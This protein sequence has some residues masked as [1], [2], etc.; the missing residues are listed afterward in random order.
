M[1]HISFESIKKAIEKKDSFP[2]V[3]EEVSD[4]MKEWFGGKWNVVVGDIDRVGWRFN[5]SP[6]TYL[7]L[8]IEQ[9]KVALYQKA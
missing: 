4:R 8:K 3:C 9:L 6:K 2:E 1:R 7:N 5:P